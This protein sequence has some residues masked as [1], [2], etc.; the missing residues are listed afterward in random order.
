[1]NI[2][3]A[4][5]AYYNELKNIFVTGEGGLTKNIQKF[6]SLSGIKA[7]YPSLYEHFLS[8]LFDERTNFIYNVPLTPFAKT[9]P[10]FLMSFHQ[11]F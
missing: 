10:S 8:E 6:A 7:L 11:P 5:Q 2:K 3:T 9:N 1:M 4:L